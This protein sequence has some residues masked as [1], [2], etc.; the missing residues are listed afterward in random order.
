MEKIEGQGLF[1]V[2]I[3]N[4]INRNDYEVLETSNG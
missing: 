2:V 1:F 4:K 3:D